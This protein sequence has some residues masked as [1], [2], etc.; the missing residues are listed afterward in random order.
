[1]PWTF[2]HP[3]I[4][5]PIMAL[6]AVRKLARPVYVLA[7]ML[8]A[9]S[10]D[11]GYYLGSL[12][13][14]LAAHSFL[15]SVLLCIPMVWLVVLL[16]LASYRF[17]L[18]PL[19]SPHQQIWHRWLTDARQNCTAQNAVW[20]S[21]CIWCGALS[22]IAWDHFTHRTGWAVLHWPG[23]FDARLGA[24]L[25][26]YE[27]LQHLSTLIGSVALFVS[28]RNALHS[29]GIDVAA[30]IATRTK[31]YSHRD[32]IGAIMVAGIV[33]A[34]MGVDAGLER[35]S[36]FWRIFYFEGAVAATQAFALVWVLLCLYLSM[37]KTAS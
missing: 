16:L 9:L 31:F 6:P 28:Y 30:A 25:A 17:L 21:L 5:L 35:P 33:G 3:A 14:K 23:V 29:S 27:L 2:A 12:G 10:P 20:I 11:F 36:Y 7:A 34:A 37:R 18:L 8:G 19:A 32:L 15:G 26:V 4:V 24:K 13:P 1:M 22:H